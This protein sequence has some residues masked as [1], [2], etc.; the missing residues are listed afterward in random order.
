MYLDV[1]K[2]R[3]DQLQKPGYQKLYLIC[4]Y[5]VSHCFFGLE[6]KSQVKNFKFEVKTNCLKDGNLEVVKVLNQKLFL[7]REKVA[8][9]LFARRS[10]FA[11]LSMS[12]QSQ[13][14]DT[15]AYLRFRDG[16]STI[17]PPSNYCSDLGPSHHLQSNSANL[18]HSLPPSSLF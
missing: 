10:V 14:W 1:R 5:W 12:E 17:S 2:G 6:N 3:T 13:F 16:L 7:R 11:A 9:A 15:T 18:R 8:Q 4:Q